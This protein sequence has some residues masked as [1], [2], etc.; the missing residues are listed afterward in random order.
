M[1]G[2]ITMENVTEKTILIAQSAAMITLKFNE[3][4]N[5]GLVDDWDTLKESSDWADET[6]VTQLFAVWAKDFEEN[7]CVG[8]QDY[9]SQIDAF[10]EEKIIRNFGKTR[11]ITLNLAPETIADIVHFTQGTVD[12]IDQTELLYMVQEVLNAGIEKLKEV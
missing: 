6:S 12:L 3:L 9:D 10:A 5:T 4:M 1:K 8:S 11:S 7:Y 2:K